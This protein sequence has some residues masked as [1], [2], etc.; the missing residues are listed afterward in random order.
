[1]N[2]IL[3][4]SVN[5]ISE[6]SRIEGKTVFENTTRVHGVIVGKIFS[7][8]NS[9]LIISETAEIEGDIQG[10]IVIVDGF[11]RGDIHALT[12]VTLSSSGRVLGNIHSP[13]IS[14]DFGAHFEGACSMQ[15]PEKLTSEHPAVFA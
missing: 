7:K 8:Q 11:V 12:K 14:I 10:D 15:Q 9:T 4:T 13:V 3:E 5:I 6:G 1:M 2:E